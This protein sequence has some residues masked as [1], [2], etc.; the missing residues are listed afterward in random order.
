[1]RHERL[2]LGLAQTL[3]HGFF[4]T[5]QTCAVLVFGQFA[6]ATHATVTQVVDVIDFATAVAQVHQDLHHGQDVVV[7]QNHRACGFWCTHFGVEL[8]TTH[9]R[10]IVRVWVVEQ[11]LE[12][13]L[14]R[15]FCRWLARAHHAIDGHACSEFVHGFVCTQSLRNVRT[16]VEFVGVDTLQFLHAGFAQFLEQGFCQLIVG[17][18]NQFAGVA[19]DDVLGQHAAN[20]EIFWH[21]DVRGFAFVQLAG[22]TC[23]HALV[24]GNDHFAGFVSDV[25][26]SHFTAQTLGHKFHLCAAVHQAEVVVHEEV[27]EDGFW[28]QAD[29]F[30]QNRHGHLAATVDAEVQ[31]VFGIEFEIEP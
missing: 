3:F 12:Q 20:Q 28:C 21:A 15:I 19:V 14:H 7:G 31:Q 30:Q 13:G 24:F 8:H 29:G 10:Q 5:C 4:D 9:A 18:G 25:K 11:T 2:L 26:A 23:S 16:L 6:H 22:V 17:T 1:M 27:R